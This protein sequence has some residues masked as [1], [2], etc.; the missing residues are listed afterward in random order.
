MYFR[1]SAFRIQAINRLPHGKDIFF[2]RF[3]FPSAVRR[4]VVEVTSVQIRA[5]NNL[6]VWK[7]IFP[8]ASEMLRARS[9]SFKDLR[10]DKFWKVTI[11]FNLQRASTTE[12]LSKRN[13]NWY[14][15]QTY[16][17]MKFCNPSNNLRKYMQGNSWI[18]SEKHSFTVAQVL[19]CL[20]NL[21]R[22]NLGMQAI[23]PHHE[24]ANLEL[25]RNEL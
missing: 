22:L 13:P 20:H 6:K 21:F 5:E 1:E 11:Y 25:P 17:E 4:L 8:D 12:F 23:N 10:S 24:I 7:N 3:N 16:I 14:Y 19:L 18:E 2:Y 15:S 9:L